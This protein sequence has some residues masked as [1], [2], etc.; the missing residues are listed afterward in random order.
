[1]SQSMERWQPIAGHVRPTYR[2]CGIRH[3]V[4]RVGD[5]WDRVRKEWNNTSP[6]PHGPTKTPASSWPT[7]E[8]PT[9]A[10]PGSH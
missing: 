2:P 4:P 7:P 10:S 6:Y 8:G 9:N 5:T 3:R 1:V